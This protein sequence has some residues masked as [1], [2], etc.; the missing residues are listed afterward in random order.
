[1]VARVPRGHERNRRVPV[2][3]AGHHLRAAA[4]QLDSAVGPWIG[5]I[6]LNGAVALGGDQDSCVDAEASCGDELEEQ[7]ANRL[8]LL[9]SLTT[10]VLA[11]VPDLGGVLRAIAAASS[12][13]VQAD[14]GFQAAKDQ[15]QASA[16]AP[17]GLMS[18][19]RA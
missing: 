3:V 12:E 2:L 17:P 15:Q 5:F 7:A 9:N 10:T 18:L 13:A 16:A 14:P 8:R 6:A 19:I 4:G 1:M 11:G